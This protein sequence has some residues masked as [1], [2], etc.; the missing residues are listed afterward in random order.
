MVEGADRPGD[1]NQALIELGSTV[2]KPREPVCGD[3][4][5]RGWCKAYEL[6][7][8]KVSQTSRILVIG[9]LTTVYLSVAETRR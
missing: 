3:C 6:S 7:K 8:A 4:P 1:I 2:C 5:V 9:F